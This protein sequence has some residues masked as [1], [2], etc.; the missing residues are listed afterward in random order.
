MIRRA[1]S[2]GRLG[3]GAVL[4]LGAGCGGGSKAS[5]EPYTPTSM[6]E[7]APTPVAAAPAPPEPEAPPAPPPPS[8]RAE[9]TLV[10][11]NGLDKL[12]TVELEQV[13]GTV[14][15]TGHF[16]HLRPGLHGFYVHTEGDCGG[17]LASNAGLHFNPG[18][19]KHGPIGAALRHVGDFG[20]LS[21][22]KDGNASFAM[23]TDSLTVTP[24]ADSVTGRAI[25]IH[26]RKDDGKTQPSGSAGPAVACG[27]IHAPGQV[28]SISDAAQALWSWGAGR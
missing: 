6:D 3:A 5:P 9:A 18:N 2:F 7:A 21:V 19:V 24:G 15:V 23:T 8:L 4:V 22:D 16:S 11:V 1:L 27:V 26:A 17:K 28:A 25:I 20:N 10:A 13:G 14:S 12:G